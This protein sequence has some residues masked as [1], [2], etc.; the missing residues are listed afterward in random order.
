MR[1]ALA[2]RDVGAVYRR[3]RDVGVTQREIAELT[4]MRQSEVS[5]IVAGRRVKQVDVLERICD[6]LGAPRELMGFCYGNRA[7]YGGEVTVADP[8]EVEKML[9]RHL[10][11]LGGRAIAGATV[12][13]FGELLAELPAPS[14]AL[15]PAQ[16]TQVHVRQV[17]DVTRRLAE[18][19]NRAVCAP[20]ML[21]AGA[22]WAT[23]LLNV[24]GADPVKR[25]LKVA[26]AELH[27]EAGWA[28]F[29]TE[30]AYQRTLHHYAQ[31]LDLA[32]EAGDVYLKAIILRYAGMATAE[33][34]HP[35]DGLKMLQCAQ[36]AAWDISRGEERAVV[37][38]ETG[39][40]AV[41]ATGLANGATVISL[42]GDH[43]TAGTW[44]AKSRELW[45]PTRAD[46][47]GDLDRPAAELEIQRG[48][49]DH[50]ET[51][52]AASVRR[53]E[54]GS[55]IS[56]TLSGAVLATV[57]V[58]AGESDGLRMAHNTITTV[59]RISSAR[60]RKRLEPLVSALDAR[61]G[62]DYQELARV[63]RQVVMARGRSA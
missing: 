15:L 2:A 9:R 23:R 8:E 35:N 11:A 1:R 43:N 38:G 4:S 16:L 37:V 26:V 22:A 29:Y 12:A 51:L 30:L 42:L 45:T 34:G 3:L 52:A 39:R 20:D 36:V 7:T 17:Q 58:R 21:S 31:A 33:Q 48:R 53:W 40:A 46:P 27:I 49:L 56:Q 59:S 63:A 50:A 18:A 54:G 10:I 5:E 32:D 61:R 28:A 25:A 60:T 41:E 13:K 55:P 14:P 6:G 57:H 44:L 62:S 24:A 19:D 47:Y